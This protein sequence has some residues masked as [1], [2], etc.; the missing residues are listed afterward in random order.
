MANANI[1]PTR[2]SPTMIQIT[3]FPPCNIILPPEEFLIRFS[4]LAHACG[5]GLKIVPSL[6]VS[7]PALVAR[8]QHFLAFGERTAVFTACS[9]GP[10]YSFLRKDDLT[11]AVRTN[12]NAHLAQHADHFIVQRIEVAVMGHQ[13]R[14]H[15]EE[16]DRGSRQPGERSQHQAGEHPYVAQ[17]DKQIARAAE[18]R[19]ECCQRHRIEKRKVRARSMPERVRARRA[20]SVSMAT[21]VADPMSQRGDVQMSR[22]VKVKMKST[23]QK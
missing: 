20:M 18:P 12:G 6:H 3:A 16:H 8:D 22:Q 5:R 4:F 14:S 15:K 21:A 13:H 23:A 9:T 10:A 19:Q 7:N 1:K 11:R 17:M 2:P